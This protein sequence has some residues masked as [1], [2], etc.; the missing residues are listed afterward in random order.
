M[1]NRKRLSQDVCA[2][3]MGQCELEVFGAVLADRRCHFSIIGS[4][5]LRVHRSIHQHMRLL[6]LYA[7][8]GWETKVAKHNGEMVGD[9]IVGV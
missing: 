5:K 1:F 9:G 7:T 3:K 4:S 8:N 6:L 2:L